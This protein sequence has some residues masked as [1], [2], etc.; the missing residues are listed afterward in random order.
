VIATGHQH[1]FTIVIGVVLVV[2]GAVA[3]AQAQDGGELALAVL[4]VAVGGHTVF[5]FGA[6]APNRVTLDESGVLLQA[7]TRRVCIPWDELV[8]VRPPAW[9]LR[10][11]TL[12]WRRRSGRPVTTLNAFP[13]LHKIL[14]E[15]ERRAPG[16]SS[17][18]VQPTACGSK[19]WN[20]TKPQAG[21]ARQPSPRRP[22]HRS[23]VDPVVH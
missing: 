2:V 8:S 15:I 5:F 7:A 4:I 11:E 20:S 3:L 22:P 13:K 21:R 1:G 10:R 14:I 9:D 17:G 19:R 18:V 6:C 12:R 16:A 23:A